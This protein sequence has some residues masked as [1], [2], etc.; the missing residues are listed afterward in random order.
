MCKDLASRPWCVLLGCALEAEACMAELG[1]SGRCFFGFTSFICMHSSC[2]C[3]SASRCARPV[4]NG[5]S[6]TKLRSRMRL[7][8]S[9]GEISCE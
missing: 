7:V 8:S 4:A 6:A 9:G 5:W 2:A 3:M 1:D